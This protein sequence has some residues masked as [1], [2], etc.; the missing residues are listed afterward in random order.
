MAD[1][2]E[3]L[4][5]GPTRTVRWGQHTHPGFAGPRT[6]KLS[7]CMMREFVLRNQLNF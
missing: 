6:D 3:I 5:R 7:V 1:K 2:S 4:F